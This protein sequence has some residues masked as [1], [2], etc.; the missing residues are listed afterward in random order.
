MDYFDSPK[1]T[2]LGQRE[3]ALEEMMTDLL[4][5]LRRKRGFGLFFVQCHKVQGEEIIATVRE[6]LPQ[7][8]VQVF[9]LEKESESLYDEMLGAYQTETFDIAFVVG[10]D[11]A[12]LGY[13]DTRRIAGWSSQEIY[14]TSWKGVPILLGHLNRQREAF[15]D[16]IPACIVFLV[17]SYVID[18][19]VQR[20]ADFFDWRSGFFKVPESEETLQQ[21]AKGMIGGDFD[22][23]KNLSHED[24]L[25]RILEIRSLVKE[26]TLNAENQAKLLKEQGRLFHADQDLVKALDCYD[27]AII[28]QS[29]DPEIWNNRGRVLYFLN[30]DEE[31]VSSYDTALIYRSDYYEALNNRGL[32]LYYLDRHEEAIASYDKALQH[33]PD[34]HH[35]WDNRGDALRDLKRYEEA[36]AS[37]DAALQ[38]KPDYHYAWNGRGNALSDLERYEEAIASY[39][40]ALQHKP[41]FHYA[42]FNRGNAL[43]NLERYEEAI[44]SYDKA[45]QHKPDDH[46]AWNSRGIALYYLERYEEAIA[47]YD[48]ALQH[49]PALLINAANITD[50]DAVVV[51]PLHPVAW[52]GN[53]PVFNYLAVPFNDK[54][55]AGGLPVQHFFVVAVNAVCRCR[56]C[57]GGRVQ[58]D[59]VNWSHLQ[60]GLVE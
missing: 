36:I 19:F 2:A 38:H 43:G 45:L 8:R 41:D 51:V 16:N 17:P 26:G 46:D 24:R 10:V 7:K 34:Y 6:R 20:A 42:W 18:Y 4:R 27:R 31:A 40:E 54:V 37:Y 22:E 14:T 47:S 32:A 56:Y 5:A 50:V 3:T 29:N 15:A 28:H 44:A 13:E 53:R 59:V 49:K 1:L 33:K 52:F 58:N 23:Y 11:Q 25:A 60:M 30:R 57:A 12:V 48:E 39:D 55:V 9:E 21:S 35:A